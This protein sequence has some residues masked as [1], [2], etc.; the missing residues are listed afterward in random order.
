MVTVQNV[1]QYKIIVTIF[2]KK[3]TNEVDFRASPIRIIGV[4]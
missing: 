4:K 3:K 2:E 1:L